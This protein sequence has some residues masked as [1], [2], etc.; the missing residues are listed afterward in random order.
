M[1]Y[2]SACGFYS[3]GTGE[4][5]ESLDPEREGCDHTYTAGSRLVFSS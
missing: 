4:P 3:K 1:G 2:D 5:C